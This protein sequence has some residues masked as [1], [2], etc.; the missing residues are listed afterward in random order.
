[1][2][3]DK[4][5][6]LQ[7]FFSND[8]RIKK[9][10]YDMAPQV[11]NGYVDEESVSK[12]TDKLND[13]LIYIFSELKCITIDM[14]GKESNVFNRLCYLEQTIKSSFYS[15]GLDIN[16]LKLFYQKFI[17]NME[18][19]FIDSVKSTCKG[20]AFNEI[21]AVNEA[22]SINEYLYFMH[23][24]IVNNDTILKSLPLICEKKNDQ[25][26]SISLRGNRNPIFEQLF[27]M[28][29]SDLDCGIT[30]MVIIDDKKLIVMVRDIGHALSMEV[31]L[32]NDMARVEYFI[33]KLCNIEM[34]NKLPGVNKVNE[35][36]VGA[37]GI[38]EVKI[39]DLPKTLFDFISM[40]PTDLDMFNSYGR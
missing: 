30:D 16:K 7:H 34:I 23:S 27:A 3:D 15:C 26:Y 38:M 18:P 22:S 40:V 12:Y 13:S 33:P 17:S 39:S 19:N 2:N 35:N 37:T 10:I 25:E 31:S 32:N 11:L 29:P 6:K 36:S 14:F 5:I 4:M 24:Y 21:S 28:F 8:I 20:Y 9:E 1:M